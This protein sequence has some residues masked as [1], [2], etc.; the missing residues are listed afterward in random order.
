MIYHLIGAGGAGMSVV[1]QLL[2]ARGEHVSGSDRSHSANLD[3]LRAAG[4]T[5]YVGHQGEHVPDDAVIVVS[6]AIRED[7]P[8]L[9]RAR[10]LGLEVIHRSQA[11]ARA[12]CDR[13]FVAV[14][15]AHGKTS[16]SAMLSVALESLGRDPS[17]AIGGNL[18]GGLS[19][20]HLG[21]GP[22][23]IAEADESDGSFLNY[24]PRIAIVTNVEPDHLD[25]YG[26][27]EAFEQAFVDFA[28]RIEFGGLLICCADS[29]GAWALAQQARAAGIRTWTYGVGAG[30]EHHASIEILDPSRA[31]VTFRGVP[32][33]LHLSV[34]GNHNLLNATAALL[35]GVELGE[36]LHQMAQALAAF[37]GTGRRFEQRAE[38][39]GRRIIDDY[40]HHP[41]EVRATLITAREQ[42]AATGGR[43]CV[44][45]QPHLYS[46]TQIFAQE[47]AQALALADE[48]VVTSVYAAR[49][50]PSAGAEADVITAHLPG[51]HYVPDRYEAAARIAQLS[52][53]G[54]I[55]LTMGAGDVTELADEIAD[56]VR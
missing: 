4:A 39:A 47:F 6:S 24:T 50:E 11:L 48:V 55:I 16:T 9:V 44:L 31:R 45:F 56:G 30:L 28:H 2:C 22:V 27:Q 12:A 35:A 36:E 15:G 18:A 29:P 53:S 23:F 14:A 1:G 25:H 26:S 51:A 3:R 42:V 37:R 52:Q 20:A 19:G 13:D 38:V 54:D 34:P 17:R 49:E 7:N 40:A 8:E 32:A 21:S 10:E 46:R 33:E 43:V 41:T 5:V